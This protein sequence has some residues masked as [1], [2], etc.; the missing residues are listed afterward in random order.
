MH[1]GKSDGIPESEHVSLAF[2]DMGGYKAQRTIGNILLA[3]RRHWSISNHL[4][5]ELK[6]LYPQYALMVHRRIW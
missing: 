2:G 6:R 1:L 3:K 5:Q 4:M